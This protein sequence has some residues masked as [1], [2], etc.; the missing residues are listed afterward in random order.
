MSNQFDG[1]RR[2]LDGGDSVDN[3]TE[4]SAERSLWEDAYEGLIGGSNSS[5]TSEPE[6]ASEEPEYLVFTPLA[7]FDASSDTVASTNSEPT[8][9][10]TGNPISAESAAPPTLETDQ[11]LAL[12]NNEEFRRDIVS[13]ALLDE[14][15][16]AAVTNDHAKA[17]LDDINGE[18]DNR[19]TSDPMVSSIR[20]LLAAH[21]ELRQR[22]ADAALRGAEDNSMGEFSNIIGEV[23]ISDPVL[24][25]AIKNQI[26]YPAL[27]NVEDPHSQRVAA[28]LLLSMPELWTN[29]DAIA[30]VTALQL[31]Q[32][33]SFQTAYDNA[34]QEVRLWFHARASEYHRFP[35]DDPFIARMAFFHVADD[36]P[37]DVQRRQIT[38]EQEM[39]INQLLVKGWGKVWEYPSPEVTDSQSEYYV[40]E[41]LEQESLSVA[42]KPTA[43]ELF[44]TWGIDSNQFSNEIEQA[45][46]K[47]GM[48][49]LL[50]AD[51]RLA[52]YNSL[53]PELRNEL[54]GS[55]IEIPEQQLAGLVLNGRLGEEGAVGEFLTGE[56]N[57]E[58][59][60]QELQLNNGEELADAQDQ[61]ETQNQ[62][63]RAALQALVKSAEDGPGWV[64]RLDRLTDAPFEFVFG[65]LRT[66]GLEQFESDQLGLVS[67][68]IGSRSMLGPATREAI[69]LMQRQANLDFS[70]N[71]YAYQD[72]MQNEGSQEV[73]DFMALSMLDRYGVDTVRSGA[74]DVWNALIDGGLT[75]LTERGLIQSDQIEQFS[76][77]PEER[78]QQAL[79]LLSGLKQSDS[80]G[81]LD[82]SFRREQALSVIDND[83]SLAA[84]QEQVLDFGD[85]FETL[86]RLLTAGDPGT[87]YDAYAAEVKGSAK[88]LLQMLDRVSPRDIQNLEQT[89]FALHE[90]ENRSQDEETSSALNSR[91]VA[92]QDLHNLL[93]PNSQVNQH[94][95]EMLIS[96]GTRDFSADNM[97]NWLGD[98]GP[99]IAVGTLAFVATVAS[100]NP[101]VGAIILGA[102]TSVGASQI[103]RE[104]LYLWNHN[105]GDTGWGGYNDRSYAGSWSA[106]HDFSSES[107]RDLFG[108]FLGEVAAPLSMEVGQNALLGIVGLGAA[109]FGQEGLKGFSRQWFRSLVQKSQS[110]STAGVSASAESAAQAFTLRW[111]A[112]MAQRGGV[113][114]G[115][116]L[117]GEAAEDLIVR[118]IGPDGTTSVILLSISAA[119][120]QGRVNAAT[121]SVGNDNRVSVDQSSLH[122]LAHDLRN[123]GFQVTPASSGAFWVNAYGSSDVLIVDG[124]LPSANNGE[125]GVGGDASNVDGVNNTD[126]H[127]IETSGGSE[128]EYSSARVPANALNEFDS[129]T[130]DSTA[131]GGG[132]GN[133]LGPGTDRNTEDSIDNNF[134]SGTHGR[135]EGSAN[136]ELGNHTESSIESG[137][138]RSESALP[139]VEETL[140]LHNHLD[141][142]TELDTR[143]GKLRLLSAERAGEGAQSEVFRIAPCSEYPDGAIFKLCSTSQGSTPSEWGNRKLRP[144]D[145]AILDGP[146]DLDNG[147]F[148]LIQESLIVPVSDNH[149]GWPRLEQL[150]AE[151]GFEWVDGGKRQVGID[152]TGNLVLL[153]Y[154]AV[155]PVGDGS[156]IDMIGQVQ[157]EQ[158]RLENST[159]RENDT[160]ETPSIGQR[161]LDADLEER[162]QTLGAL[163][164]PA[165]KQYL[166]DIFLGVDIEE[167]VSLRQAELGEWDEGAQL[168][169]ESE[170]KAA[171]EWAREGGLLTEG[172]SQ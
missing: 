82:L 83:P 72:L 1:Q 116:E 16:R 84:V 34:P 129:S 35:P 132:D 89:I 148:A 110:M 46:T 150:M 32:I 4:N 113:E 112:Q 13:H 77:S 37:T 158:E 144:F 6:V 14:L 78:Y 50:A 104:G 75:R 44:S 99:A 47:Y 58:H 117:T 31:D 97:E 69:D 21:P 161:E 145:A 163:P 141:A 101:G 51:R 55:S 66:D 134:E 165:W 19:D 88:E 54:V 131:T 140:R 119:M 91:R 102:G 30:A 39:E 153:D 17:I 5:P 63:Y 96:I 22:L 43:E 61:L 36:L 60:F 105:R 23:A 2:N 85:D 111:M 94:Y 65:N 151:S 147:Y 98:N 162:R 126:N 149:P 155:R 107:A 20:L 52:L 100:C 122:Q 49:T 118:A 138:G 128:Y 29:E 79:D 62:E 166:D 92:L 25:E 95:R 53:S 159:V 7:G 93:S 26:I 28:S 90:A 164:D 57:F 135:I 45:V 81:N 168:R 33:S 76:S 124:N 59:L 121:S 12:P 68:F 10:T 142:L 146:Q 8:R 114:V 167:I 87:A 157:E 130:E 38:E 109:R 143:F 136:Y 170:V 15:M 40:S 67:E 70:K 108:S 115:Q 127:A 137:A 24:A 56:E 171:I 172:H 169:I 133:D 86:D 139:T 152:E 156:S 123:S 160:D 41:T 18:P 154:D 125:T 9:D 42:R 80:S 48:E 106:N 71:V 103:T 3:L 64:D 27:N 120:L 74:P 73:L 11:A